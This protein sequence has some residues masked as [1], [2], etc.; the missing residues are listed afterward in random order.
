MATGEYR[1]WS[2][3]PEKSKLT[4]TFEEDLIDESI[5]KAS[6]SW[7]TFPQKLMWMRGYSISGR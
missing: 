5:E 7:D 3:K 4:D 1:K 2:K 6:H